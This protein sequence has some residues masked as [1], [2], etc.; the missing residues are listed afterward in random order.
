MKDLE[1]LYN[2]EKG[3]EKR[4]VEKTLLN[5]N[6]KVNL[7]MSNDGIYASLVRPYS[8][9]DFFITCIFR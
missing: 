3:N 9:S 7:D 4:V 8:K 2:I 1:V 6:F 5:V